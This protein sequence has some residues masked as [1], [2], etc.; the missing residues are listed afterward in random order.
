[1]T[2]ELRRL[3]VLLL[4]R[5]DVKKKITISE[6]D[7]KTTYEIDK[8]KFNIAEKRRVTQLSFPDNAAAAKAYAELAKAKV[9]ADAA[10][11]LGFKTTDTDLGVITK[12]DMIDARIA[13]AAFALKKDELSQPVAGTFGV[14]L[15][16]VT[17]IEAGKQRTLD[18]VKAEIVD[19]L[20]GERAQ[21]DI[22]ALHDEIENT[23]ASGKTLKEIADKYSLTF[24]DVAATDRAAKA[25]DG[26]P[27]LEHPDAQRIVQAAFGGVAG[28]EAEATELADGGYAWFDVLA[29]TPEAQRPL[30]DVKAEVTAAWTTAERTKELTA[31]AASI[32]TRIAKGEAFPAI[33][34]ELGLKLETTAAVTRATS[35]QGLTANAVQ[36][37][38]ALP[39]GTASSTAT[40]D[41]A[42]RIVFRTAEVIPA[43][44]A[45]K[46]QTDR[47]KAELT[48][49]LQGD[50]LAGYISGLQARYGVS[51]N[52]AAVR[53]LLGQDRTQ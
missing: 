26:R 22:Q 42:S 37:A 21:R 12:A 7:I 49:Q 15:L 2:P 50:V 9:F 23:R 19:R 44:A 25:R 27:A 28:V 34:K 10:A 24:R 52:E 5:D 53:Q 13:D 41:G 29:T 11:K 38:F 36:Q 48:R 6:D 31:F 40:A 20:A 3:A 8:E 33:A 18:D 51:V 32:V 30:D 17:E 4:Q 16:R 14:V 46:E 47:L 39:A 43:L 1:M 35:P 45:T